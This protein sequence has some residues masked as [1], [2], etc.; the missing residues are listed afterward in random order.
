M[1][2]QAQE[3]RKFFLSTAEITQHIFITRAKDSQALAV[4]GMVN[5]KLAE[6]LGF[7]TQN[8]HRLPQFAIVK[9]SPLDKKHYVFLINV[10]SHKNKAITSDEA[11]RLAYLFNEKVGNVYATNV[12][13]SDECY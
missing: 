10:V 6:E 5:P 3:N 2:L 8:A 9:K 12:F 4:N 11:D 7:K 1:A 13:E